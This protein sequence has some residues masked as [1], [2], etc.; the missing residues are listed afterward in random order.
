MQLF[1]QM[2]VTAFCHL[3]RAAVFCTNTALCVA[4][5]APAQHEWV[6][7]NMSKGQEGG[8][9]YIP[10]VPTRAAVGHAIGAQQKYL[11]HEEAGEE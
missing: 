2:R 8:R 5:F 3:H 11:R 7:E 6:N 4:C 10:P 1:R 9:T